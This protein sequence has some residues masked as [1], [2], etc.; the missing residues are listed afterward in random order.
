MK[1]LVAY[2][3]LQTIDI[4]AKAIQI[5]TG[6]VDA[7]TGGVLTDG[8]VAKGSEEPPK[9]KRGFWA[10]FFGVRKDKEKKDPKKPQ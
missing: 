10:R 8:A 1:G 2:P 4:V 7:P 9:K 3:L 6:Q 5:L